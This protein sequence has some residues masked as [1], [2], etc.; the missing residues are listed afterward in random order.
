MSNQDYTAFLLLG[1][2]L[3][4]IDGQLIYRGGRRYLKSAYQDAAAES[5]VRLVTVLFHLVMLGVLALISVL[6]L[7][8]T[9]LPAV[10]IRVGILLLILAAGH[11]VS[12]VIITGRRNAQYDRK[13]AAQMH[14][15]YEENAGIIAVDRTPTGIQTRIRSGEQAD[16]HPIYTPMPA[17]DPFLTPGID[18]DDD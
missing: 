11:A 4:V 8:A 6:G 3:V 17:N 1:V 12:T 14:Q 18:D 10:M 2:I 13:L 15:R 7:S 16:E 5:F 9:G